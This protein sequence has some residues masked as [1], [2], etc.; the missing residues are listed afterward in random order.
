MNIAIIPARGGSKRIVDKNIKNFCGKPM[1]FWTIEKLKK[2][3]IFD[4]IYISTDSKKISKV[5]KNFNCDLLYPRPKYL[6]NDYA[7]T[8]EVVKY[9]IKKINESKILNVCCMYPAAPLTSINDIIKGYKIL[10]KN[11][12]KFIIPSCKPTFDIDRVYFKKKNMY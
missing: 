3:K 1:I 8:L 7:K 11:K 4:K 10:K 12:D 6:S 5:V 2:T 9:E